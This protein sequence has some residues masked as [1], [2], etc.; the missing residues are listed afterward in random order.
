MSY[1]SRSF[2]KKNRI[3]VLAHKILA[4]FQKLTVEAIA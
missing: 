4:I 1:Y 2:L 3:V